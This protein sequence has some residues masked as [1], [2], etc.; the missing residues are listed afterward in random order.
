MQVWNMQLAQLA[1]VRFRAYKYPSFSHSGFTHHLFLVS[2]YSP[3]DSILIFQP[4]VFAHIF[5]SHQEIKMDSTDQDDDTSDSDDMSA[6]ARL[7]RYNISDGPRLDCQS[8]DLE[9]RRRSSSMGPP[10]RTENAKF[11]KRRVQDDFWEVIRHAS[12]WTFDNRSPS[13]RGNLP[14]SNHF[15][16]NP[17]LFRDDCAELEGHIIEITTG[18]RSNQKIARKLQ[19]YYPQASLRNKVLAWVTA[20]ALKDQARQRIV[21]KR[22]LV[23]KTHATRTLIRAASKQTTWSLPRLSR[24]PAPRLTQYRTVKTRTTIW[25]LPITFTFFDPPERL[26]ALAGQ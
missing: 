2:N 8:F 7:M 14:D 24:L 17:A 19:T 1:L 21:S 15:S 4:P 10:R 18:P 23:L 11:V 6:G 20:I 16:G 5:T 25:S 3:F 12:A 26:C 22:Q 13:I 9:T